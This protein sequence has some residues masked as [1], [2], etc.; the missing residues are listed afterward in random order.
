MQ[1]ATIKRLCA[2]LCLLF[3][4]FPLAFSQSGRNNRQ[5]ANKRAERQTQTDNSTTTEKQKADEPPQTEKANEQVSNEDIVK[6]N[7]NLVLVP[8]IVSDRSDIYIPDLK[9]EDFE[10]YEDDVKQE[11]AFFGTVTQP[12]HVV[13]MLDTSASTQE[14]IKQ[15]QEASSAFVEQ[16][17][18]QDR[19]KIISFDDHVYTLSDFTNDRDELRRA[20]YRTRPG[21]GTKLYDAMGV[22]IAALQKVQGRKAIVI[23]TDGVDW[24]SDYSSAKK[25]REKLEE[26]GIIVYPIRY[27][28]REAV[29]RLIRQQRQEGQVVDLNVIFGT[30]VPKSG[31]PTTFPGGTTHPPTGTNPPIGTGPFPPTS[32]TG[33]LPPIV[34]NRPS[35]TKQPRTNDPT[36]P[37]TDDPG[38]LIK[39]ELD[40]AYATADA[41]LKE[42]A[43]ITGGRLHRADTLGAL[44]VAFGKIADELRTQYSIGYYP[45]NK[46]RDG[47]FRKLKVKTTRKN[48]AVRARPGYRAPTGG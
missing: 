34:I 24:Y 28:T 9:R 4:L 42:L 29:E 27:D 20:I 21:Q 10:L 16:L 1:H 30:G 33:P 38:D 48:A 46:A 37:T 23:F 25:N 17:Q 15:I 43:E 32:Q 8:V 2:L 3:I 41:Y 7:T 35:T 45:T 19:V 14:K 22:A 31:T 18:T 36:R 44:P 12:F 13:L 39:A 47:K 40:M 11:I 5:T 6:V 26:A